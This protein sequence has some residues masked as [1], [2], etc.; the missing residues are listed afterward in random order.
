MGRFHIAIT[1][2]KMNIPRIGLFYLKVDELTV[3]VMYNNEYF[4][5]E[6]ALY[7]TPKKPAFLSLGRF[8]SAVTPEEINIFQIGLF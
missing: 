3:F 6:C 4:N 8:Q 1:P 5:L 7:H 2:D